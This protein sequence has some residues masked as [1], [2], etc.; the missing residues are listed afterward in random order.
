MGISTQLARDA[1]RG[2][3]T[4]LVDYPGVRVHVVG[5]LHAQQLTLLALSVVVG[6]LVDDAIVEMRTSNAHI[7]M[8]K[9]VFKLPKR[10]STEIG[11]R[12]C[13]DDGARRR[14][15]PHIIYERRSGIVFREFGWT[16]VAA[17]LTLLLVARLLSR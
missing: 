5:R 12:H 3:S 2:D 4:T 7:H 13:D 1:F 17:I 16:A 8:G 9:S 15:S 11:R 6:I 14:I 10:R